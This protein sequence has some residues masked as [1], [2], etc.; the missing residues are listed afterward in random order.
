[1]YATGKLKVIFAALTLD[2]KLKMTYNNIRGTR[3]TIDSHWR[4]FVRWA[5][6]TVL[7]DDSKRQKRSKE[8]TR[9]R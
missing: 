5:K 2:P 7:Y 9:A 3:S 6:E 1:M 4:K 8:F